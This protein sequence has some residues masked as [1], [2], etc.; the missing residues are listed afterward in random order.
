MLRIVYIIIITPIDKQIDGRE[1]IDKRGFV[2]RMY[3][4]YTL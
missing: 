2:R 3:I 1:F 4:F